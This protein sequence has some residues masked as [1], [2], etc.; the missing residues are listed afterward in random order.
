[1]IFA[2]FPAGGGQKE[3]VKAGWTR[4]SR[5]DLPD[6][7]GAGLAKDGKVCFDARPHLNPLPPGEDLRIHDSVFPAD[8]PA[9]PAAGIFK[10]AARVAPSPWGEGR[11]E[12]GRDSN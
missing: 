5:I 11:V 2:L 7:P 4:I 12:G 9:N 1:M 10:G 3:T 6:N 8:H